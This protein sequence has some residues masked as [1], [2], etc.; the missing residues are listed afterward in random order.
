MAV[1]INKA[2]GTGGSKPETASKTQA[3]WM[4][5][6]QKAQNAVAQAEAAAAAAA[7]AA[8]KLQRF[9]LMNGGEASITF[10]DGRLSKEGTLDIPMW[11]E[12]KAPVGGRWEN[13]VCVANVEPCPF[14]EGGDKHQLVGGLTVINHTPYTYTKGQKAGQTIGDRR[15]LYIPS[16]TALKMLQTLAGKLGADGSGLQFMRF[17]VNRTGEKE[18]RVGNLMTPMGRTTKADLLK[19]FGKDLVEAADFEKEIVYRTGAE[20]AKMGIVGP[21]TI[22]NTTA[23]DEAAAADEV[24]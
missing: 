17:D 7:E 19:Q 23:G 5:K 2:S 6:G 3:S 20:L 15:Q 10:L 9:W 22:G 8:G 16:R 24:E 4:M 18:P 21:N 11:Y 14:C 13:F 1:T 12:H